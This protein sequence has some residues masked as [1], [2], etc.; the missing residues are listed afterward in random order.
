MGVWA[1]CFCRLKPEAQQ[2]VEHC[3]YC[4]VR[5]RVRRNL[6]R[7]ARLSQPNGMNVANTF[8]RSSVELVEG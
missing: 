5:G 8:L 7:R 6:R 3:S 4:N 2:S 1:P